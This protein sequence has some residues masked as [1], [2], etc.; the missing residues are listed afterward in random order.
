MTAELVD[1]A[2]D[3]GLALNTWTV[4]D[5]DEMQRLKAL[6]VDTIVTNDVAL[7]VKTLRA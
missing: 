3:K 6:G 1:A 2:H 7:A 5:P 4:D